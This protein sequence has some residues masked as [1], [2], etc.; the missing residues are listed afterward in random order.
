MD[1][2]LDLRDLLDLPRSVLL[3]LWLQ[4][5]GAGAGPVRRLVAAV[6]GDDEPHDVVGAPL[7]AADGEPATLDALVAAWASGER[8]TAALLPVPG[9]VSGLPPAVAGPALDAGE[10]LLVQVAG[11]AWAAV[12]DVVAFGSPNDVGHLVTWHVHEVEPWDLRMPG[13]VGT[14]AEAERSL[15]ESLLRATEALTRLD[16]A[17]WRPDAAAALAAL[18]GDGD[19]R[20]PLPEG[21]APRALRVLVDAVRL[22]AV[23]SLATADDGGA[24]NL[25]QAD[26]R[27]AALREIDGAA[28]RAVAAA[29]LAV[30]LTAPTGPVT[31]ALGARGPAAGGRAAGGQARTER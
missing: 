16:V 25:W 29:T 18:R 14:L 1:D 12:P 6:Q 26:H 10:C 22:R 20:W 17:R 13:V 30:G 4:R 21:L 19:P 31:G 5:V 15:R 2:A 24:V 28:R 23:V 7:P 3:A 9:D 27:S 8:R 11:T